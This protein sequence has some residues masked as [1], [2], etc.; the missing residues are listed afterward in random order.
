[1]PPCVARRRFSLLVCMRD[2]LSFPTRRS[3]D[4]W[5]LVHRFL[6]YLLLL[7][8]LYPWL[9]NWVSVR[10]LLLV[11]SVP[12]ARS[13]MPARLPQIQLSG[14]LRVCIWTG[15]RVIFGVQ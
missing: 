4:L 14:Q 9:C 5:A 8:F 2:L 1:D 12:L 13:V 10:W 15:S 3:S 6:L 7:R 11:L